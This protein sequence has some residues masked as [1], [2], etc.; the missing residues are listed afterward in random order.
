MPISI[1]GPPGKCALAAVAMTCSPIGRSFVSNYT[2][3]TCSNLLVFKWT[4]SKSDDARRP[5]AR[6]QSDHYS[7]TTM[8]TVPL[9]GTITSQLISHEA[10]SAAVALCL[11][12]HRIACCP[13][14]RSDQDIHLFYGC[15]L[16]Q[17][18]F[19]FVLILRT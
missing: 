15:S 5:N 7:D 13:V 9:L 10:N 3:A 8:P 16:I 6:S 11:A 4:H 2:G 1:S 19:P 14:T 18:C 12:L 17:L